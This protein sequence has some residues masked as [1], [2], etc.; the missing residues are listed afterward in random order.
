MSEKIVIVGMN[1]FAC[2]C[3]GGT[4]FLPITMGMIAWLRVYGPREVKA[5]C[6]EGHESTVKVRAG[7]GS[8][9]IRIDGDTRE[10][11]Y[12]GDIPETEGVEAAT[13]S[14]AGS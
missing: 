10:L 14:H 5:L 1:A 4:L 2:D 9:V 6:T 8:N 11:A 3:K 12:G 13:S 7:R